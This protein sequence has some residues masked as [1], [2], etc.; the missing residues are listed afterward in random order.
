MKAVIA[1]EWQVLLFSY[2]HTNVSTFS[3]CDSMQGVFS[4]DTCLN[5]KYYITIIDD[6]N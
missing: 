6:G 2:S 1:S 4:M 3:A 5:R